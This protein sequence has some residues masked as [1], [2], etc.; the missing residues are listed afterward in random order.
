LAIKLTKTVF[1]IDIITLL[2]KKR[3]I[4]LRVVLRGF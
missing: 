1:K 3:L 2:K 4:L